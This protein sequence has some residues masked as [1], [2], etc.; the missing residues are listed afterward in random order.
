MIV[1]GT[2]G[3]D[4]LALTPTGSASASMT[5]DGSPAY[6][7]SNI[8]QFTFNSGA[9][10]DLMTV[11]D[12]Q[13]LLGLSGG[14]Q[15]DGGTG[16]NSLQLLQTGGTAE[17]SDTY[18]VFANPGQGSDV[19][20]GPGGT[21]TI[22]FQ[23]LAPVYDNVPAPLTVVGS[24]SN[25]TINYEAGPNSGNSSAPYNGDSTGMVT[26]DNFESL[27]FSHKTT[28]T[29]QGGN[30]DDTFAINNSTTPT[31]LTAISVDGQA[32]S[33][34]LVVDAKNQV[35]QSSMITAAQVNIPVATPVPVG[36]TGIQ[37]VSVIH[38]LDSLTSTGAA[39]TSAV[40]GL[41][42]SSALVGTFQFSDGVPP[43][44]LG[45]A[46]N[47][48]ATIDWGDGTAPSA[49]TIVQTGPDAS[50]QVIF[51][52]FGSHTYAE[53]T[54]AN[55]PYPISVVITDL[56]STRSFTPA[57]GVPVQIVDNPGAT[58]TTP[59][60]GSPGAA[61]ATVLDAPLSSSNGTAITGIE[62]SST[63]AVL[64][65]TF[66]DANPG[67]T[68]ADFTTSPASIAVNWG[69]GTPPEALT[70]ANLSAS[71]S[72]A[73]VVFSVRAAHTYAEAGKYAY[74]VIARD[75]G[76]AETVFSGTAFI[77]DAAL[78]AAPVQPVVSTVEAALFPVP[79]YA[80]PLFHGTVASFANSN[81]TA[82]QSDFVASIYWGDG[83]PLSAGT[84]TQPGGVGTAFLVSGS[85]T[86][87]D[88]GVN[89][90]AGSYAIEVFVVDTE[91][92]KL[93]LTNTA[94]VADNP[95][96][97]GGTLDP[98][99]DSGLAT[100]TLDTTDVTQ[101]D[102]SGT[103]EPLSHV[104]LFATSLPGGSPMV[105]GQVQ[106]GGDGAWKITSGV[107]LADGRYQITATAV[108]QFGVTHTAAP[109]VITAN[110][111]VDT[112]GPVIA[113]MFFNRLN[114]QV[115]YIIKDPGAT[116]SG[117]W[118]PGILD[119]ANYQLTKVHANKAYPGKWVATTITD[120]PDPTIPNAYDVA[121]TFNSGAMLRGGYYLFTIRD[122]S[123]GNA[124][125]QDLA[126]NHLDGEFY[127]AFPSGN[128]INGGDFVAELQGV[129]NKVFAPQTI[130]GTANAGNGGNGGPPVAPIHSG[131]W[132]PAIPRGAAR[133][134]PRPPAPAPEATR[135]QPRRAGC[136]GSSVPS[137]WDPARRAQRSPTDPDTARP[138][139]FSPPARIRGDRHSAHWQCVP[140]MF[141]FHR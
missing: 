121:V 117:V 122:S 106:A 34:T 64:L 133:S 42:F 112:H 55:P 98:S 113:G 68:L 43:P 4:T 111:L 35:V 74:T 130:V 66:T 97:L 54:A 62:G 30:G 7:F 3:N 38:A 138:G 101:P 125:V 11:D 139:G 126:G 67:A 141:R 40:E 16:S 18:S 29:L 15:Y 65:G 123:S 69:D 46:S 57:G 14:I 91:G 21:Q 135:P 92:A 45:S 37:Q 49:G 131:I 63:G 105:I 83:T 89:G 137:S 44:V 58:T 33:N 32:G 118:L 76:G 25:N 41:P 24:A 120:T 99:A 109:A 132:V 60:A 94:T 13:S 82:P 114:G 134:F 50:G 110:L 124:S 86:Y 103:S 72:P 104:T 28:L 108:D 22:N 48:V 129:H 19:I 93:T 47:F 36:Y 87:A 10:N 71:G 26:V 84:I 107:V 51:Q 6:S 80:P 59:A 136:L 12:S 88:S 75:A 119:S 56:G 78:A 1:L 127:G 39:I 77:A 79:V 27:E 70:A 81:P 20:T 23:N 8:N 115:D 5:F 90:G 102:F 73:G 9:G 100:G 128:G 95:I 140:I 61:L 85:H 116:P 52:V 96:A 53:E 2:S 31:G 17:T